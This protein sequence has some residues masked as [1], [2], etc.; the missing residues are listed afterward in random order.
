MQVRTNS[1]WSKWISVLVGHNLWSVT[2]VAFVPV[3]CRKEAAGSQQYGAF[4][5]D[6]A[7]VI[8]PLQVVLSDASHTYGSR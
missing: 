4:R 2:I 3:Q 6:S 5:E 7:F 8:H 1:S